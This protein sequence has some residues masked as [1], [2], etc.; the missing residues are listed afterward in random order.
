MQQLQDVLYS[1]TGAP[2]PALLGARPLPTLLGL[3]NIRAKSCQADPGQ[4]PSLAVLC[5]S[6]WARTGQA[7]I[8][9]GCLCTSSLGQSSNLQQS[10]VAE[11]RFCLF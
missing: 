9:W 4:G 7:R 8:S 5:C 6:H 11:Q 2:H 10:A 1:G 3:V